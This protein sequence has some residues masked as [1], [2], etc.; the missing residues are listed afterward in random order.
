MRTAVLLL[1]FGAAVGCGRGSAPEAPR[2]TAPGATPP[3]ETPSGMVENADY[4]NWKRFPVGT[5]VTRRTHSAIGDSKLTVTDVYTLAE[6]TPESCVVEK[7]TTVERKSAGVNDT[8]TN[9]ALPLKFQRSFAAPPGMK[10]EDFQK[11][12]LKATEAGRESVEALGKTY[13][14][15]KWT[16]SEFTEAGNKQ[17]TIWLSDAVPGRVVKQTQRQKSGTLAVE[18][19]AAIK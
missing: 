12:S 13:D 19:L 15:A 9:P 1:A 4:A 18:E 6:L 10:P 5:A 14:C 17:V 7:T 3:G 16:W 2:A 8:Q 11:P